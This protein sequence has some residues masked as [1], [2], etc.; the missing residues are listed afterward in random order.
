MV[1]SL[2]NTASVSGHAS[3][4]VLLST[5]SS[6]V[7]AAVLQDGDVECFVFFCSYQLVSW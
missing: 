6:A 2:Y 7:S 4:T 1:Q 5:V 3:A